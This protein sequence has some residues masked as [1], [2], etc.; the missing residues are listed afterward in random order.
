MDIIVEKCLLMKVFS[1]YYA[2]SS[3]KTCAIL[4]NPQGYIFVTFQATH[5]V[6]FHTRGH[7]MQ[8]SMCTDAKQ[9]L[10]TYTF[11]AHV[12]KT[13]GPHKPPARIEFH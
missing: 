2:L 3:S 4:Q 12:R 6:Y 13:G 8:D 9:I 10:F 7:K 5:T 1:H 11:A